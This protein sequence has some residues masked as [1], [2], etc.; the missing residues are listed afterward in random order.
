MTHYPVGIIIPMETE[1]VYSAITDAIKPFDER[2]EVQEY[3]RPC[4]CQE[5][6]HFKHP[7]GEDVVRDKA[8]A[9]TFKEKG[10]ECPSCHGKGSYRT[11]SNPQSKWDWWV[12]GGRWN[13]RIKNIE[14]PPE[15]DVN[16]N[17]VMCRYYLKTLE[18]D[19]KSFL[20]SAIVTP[21]GEWLEEG[22]PLYFGVMDKPKE[23]HVWKDEVISLL[24]KY[25]EYALIG[26]DCH[27]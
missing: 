25:R 21:E 26:I 7:F 11:T 19:E 27:I 12:I 23:P 17:Y 3:E 10:E 6:I 15:E 24:R 13:G 22:K 4:W 18:D 20:P 5:S 16:A 9:E 14:S 2:I 8:P 1:Y